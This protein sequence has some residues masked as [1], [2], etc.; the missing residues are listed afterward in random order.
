MASDP[1]GA[2]HDIIPAFTPKEAVLETVGAVVAILPWGGPIAA[3]LIGLSGDW[4]FER[5]KKVLLDLAERLGDVEGEQASFIRTEDF[6]DLLIEGLQRVAGE[7]NE[8]K[9]AAYRNILLHAVRDEERDYEEALRFE[10]LLE[11]LHPIHLEMLRELN[12][13]PVDTSVPPFDAMQL[14]TLTELVPSVRYATLVELAQQLADTRV[15]ALTTLS[16]SLPVEGPQDLRAQ[17]TPL[18]QRFVEYILDVD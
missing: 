11:Q 5:A 6:R 1:P 16:T 12:R 2:G 15:A 7:R 13:L 9:R 14:P 3:T 18:G 17:I 10:R 4:R 8:E